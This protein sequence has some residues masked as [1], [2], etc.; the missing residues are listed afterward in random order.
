MSPVGVRDGRDSAFSCNLSDDEREVSMELV[1]QRARKIP[2]EFNQK[3]VK[4]IKCNLCLMVQA[5]GKH[6]ENNSC[7]ITFATYFCQICRLY[8]NDTS[9]R[10]FH[11]NGCGVCKTGGRE[12][13]FHCNFCKTC[14]SVHVRHLHNHTPENTTRCIYC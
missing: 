13:F 9:K 7:K 11:C 14:V 12:N 10:I 3:A 8:D 1:H 4:K 2:H 5:P 6:C